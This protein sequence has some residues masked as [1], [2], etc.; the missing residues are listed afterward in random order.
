M[1][2]FNEIAKVFEDL[3][4][5]DYKATEEASLMFFQYGDRGYLNAIAKK[6]GL[7]PEEIL[8]MW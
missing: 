5:E 4:N 6:I 2:E 3:S 7:E 1:R 8:F